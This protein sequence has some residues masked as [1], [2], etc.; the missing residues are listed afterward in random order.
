MAM[1][2]AFQWPKNIN[3]LHNNIS[4]ELD[5]KVVTDSFSKV[6]SIQSEFDAIILQAKSKTH[7]GIIFSLHNEII[8]LLCIAFTPPVMQQKH[9]FV[10][11]FR[12]G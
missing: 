10:V 3:T 7:Y 12:D 11:H 6:T 8:I 4:F 5:C 2:T 9:N 1:L